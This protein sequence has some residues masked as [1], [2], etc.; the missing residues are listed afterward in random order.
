MELGIDKA[1]SNAAFERT[2]Y[3]ELRANCA[4]C[5]S[6]DTRARIRFNPVSPVDI[7]GKGMVYRFDIRDIGAT[8]PA[9]T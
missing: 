7:N 6:T 2:L 9:P 8:T 3:P 5:H 1:L 4:A